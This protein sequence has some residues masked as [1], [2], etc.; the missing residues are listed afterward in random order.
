MK[1]LIG[2]PTGDGTVTI[3]YLLSIRSLEE[4]FRR[5][6]PTISSDVMFGSSS[7]MPFSRNALASIVLEDKSYTHLLFVDADMGFSPE[8]VKKIIEADKDI[9]G[10]LYPKRT[11]NFKTYHRISR[12]ES[13]ADKARSISLEYAAGEMLQKKII[14][15]NGK[16][17]SVYHTDAGLIKTL[18]LG[19]GLTLI[20]RS[21]LEKM[22]ALIPEIV[23]DASMT[24]YNAMGLNGRVLQCFSSV[25]VNKISLS[26]DL[27][28]C[29]RWTEMCGGEIWACVDQLISHV[30]P[31]SF[32][33]RM[34]DRLSFE[35]DLRMN[36]NPN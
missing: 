18:R 2:T 27:S 23:V 9:I 3:Q 13:D 30:G 25:S 19:M 11:I 29:H 22:A 26:E 7:F 34:I 20:K 24:H 32:S 8:A 21:V 10:C 31:T 12:I 4:Y 14:K 6:R 1:I 33:G 28:F 36:Q 16:E 5:S 35:D 17:T 15:T